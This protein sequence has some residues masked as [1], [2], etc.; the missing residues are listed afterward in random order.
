MLSLMADCHVLH[1]AESVGIRL[2]GYVRRFDIM[3]TLGCVCNYWFWCRAVFSW[4]WGWGGGGWG[5]TFSCIGISLGTNARGGGGGGGTTYF[6]LRCT[7]WYRY[8]G[9]FCALSVTWIYEWVLWTY[10][11]LI[12]NLKDF[13]RSVLEIHRSNISWAGQPGRS[14]SKQECWFTNASRVLARSF[15]PC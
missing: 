2:V 11:K 5:K 1:R 12:L 15:R 9:I 7:R 8:C 4:T 3:F 6:F 13:I 10:C 14:C